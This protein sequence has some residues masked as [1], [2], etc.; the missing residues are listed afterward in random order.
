MGILQLA[1]AAAAT[2]FVL[3]GVPAAPADE[4]TVISVGGPPVGVAAGP[5]GTVY[6]TRCE[7][8][9]GIFVLPPGA[10]APVR[11]IRTGD[12]PSSVASAPDGTLY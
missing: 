9:G 2:A 12:F 1:A 5:D 4:G 6:V 3:F 11:T 7:W 10:T 8:G